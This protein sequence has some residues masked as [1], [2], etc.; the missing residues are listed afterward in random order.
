MEPQE[1]SL[2]V[3]GTANALYSCMETEKLE[4]LAAMF[5]QLGDTLE[6]LL[7]QK[8]YLTQKHA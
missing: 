4:V 6:T 5:V 7:A 1:L 8:A 2:F 3:A